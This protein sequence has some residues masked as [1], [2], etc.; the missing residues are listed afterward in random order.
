MSVIPSTT[1]NR[2]LLQNIATHCFGFVLCRFHLSFGLVFGYHL[3]Q[4]DSGP[5]KEHAPNAFWDAFSKG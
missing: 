2:L 4:P 1:A 3:N 5:T